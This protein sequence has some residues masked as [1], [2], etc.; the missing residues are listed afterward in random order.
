[1][2]RSPK[3]PALGGPFLV[4]DLSRSELSATVSQHHATVA[5]EDPRISNMT[6]AAKGTVANPGTH[7]RE[8]AGLNCALLDLGWG[9]FP[10]QLAYKLAARGCQVIR[11]STAYSSLECSQCGYT[12]QSNRP[13]RDRFVCVQCLYAMPCHAMPTDVKAAETIEKPGRHLLGVPVFACGF[14]VLVSAPR[15]PGGCLLRTRA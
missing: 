1:M 14:S 15:A 6:A 2:S 10:M 9:V 12:A 4:I 11:V 8:K 3:G 5:L 13:T 7:V